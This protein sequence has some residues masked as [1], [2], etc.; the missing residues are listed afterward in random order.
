MGN[1][2]TIFDRKSAGKE[3]EDNIKM[4]IRKIALR[5]DLESSG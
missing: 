4:D 2:Y 1:E 5:H 3:C